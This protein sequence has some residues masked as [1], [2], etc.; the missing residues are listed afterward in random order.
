MNEPKYF[1]AGQRA[2]ARYDL[3]PTRR[4]CAACFRPASRGC[5]VTLPSTSNEAR[6]PAA[7]MAL[8]GHCR[9]KLTHAAHD[10]PVGAPDASPTIA[11]RMNAARVARPE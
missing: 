11:G 8:C 3:K 7:S 1:P 6:K 4:R 5:S 10:L 2:R 9:R